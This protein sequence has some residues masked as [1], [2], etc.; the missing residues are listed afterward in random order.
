M[1]T[2]PSNFKFTFDF[3]QNKDFPLQFSVKPHLVEFS[4]TLIVL[5]ESYKTGL[6]FVLLFRCFTICSDMQSF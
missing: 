3:E 6:V 4:R 5:F 2:R 1:N